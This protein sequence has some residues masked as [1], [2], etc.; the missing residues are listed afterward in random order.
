M[1]ELPC[2]NCGEPFEVE[3]PCFIQLCNEC[4]GEINWGGENGEDRS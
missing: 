2:L 1:T 4:R 3:P